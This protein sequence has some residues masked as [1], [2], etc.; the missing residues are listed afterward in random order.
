MLQAK[1]ETAAARL[2]MKVGT[3]NA[4]A[5]Q[6][7]TAAA[8]R[9]RT[10]ILSEV[11]I[12]AGDKRKVERILNRRSRMIGTETSAS[13]LMVRSKGGNSILLGSFKRFNTG[14]W[15]NGELVNF[16]AKHLFMPSTT[17]AFFYSSYFFTSLLGTD[18][19]YLHSNVDTW[20]NIIP[21]GLFSLKGL[22]VP[23][24]KENEHWFFL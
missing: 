22:Y 4:R 20:S 8:L 11:S 21:G 7:S 10:G 14:I 15:L 24:N 3:G 19:G 9:D 2:F 17:G 16:T 18:N 6:P 23:I 13:D 1:W 5:Q 12:S